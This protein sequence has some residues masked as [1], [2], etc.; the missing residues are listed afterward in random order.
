M[1]ILVHAT[2]VWACAAAPAAAQVAQQAAQVY[3]GV[4]LTPKLGSTVPL[5]LTFT[6]AEREAIELRELF[7]QKKPVV[8]TFVYHTCPMLCSAVLDGLT[9]S[10][11][12]IPWVPGR[13][14]TLVA[15]SIDAEDTAERSVSVR[16]RYLGRLPHQDAHWEFLTGDADAI[17]ALTEA[18]G[19]GFKWVES[20]QE[21][22]HPAA[23]IL[24][25]SEG[26]I[27]RYLPD[28]APRPRDLRASIVEASEGTVGGLLDRAFLY[29]F[30][31]D[32]T[33]NSYVLAARRAM[34]V[35]GGLTALAL[36][37]SLSLL[38]AREYRRAGW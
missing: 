24:L 6:N 36:L 27:A 2:L 4:G 13:D 8:L 31:F 1:R 33:A 30:Q 14:F 9:R 19:F 34:K 12:E 37:A 17:A 7:G 11:Q 25:T 28:M 20:Q 38:W 15:V 5:D 32:P 23:V 35:G 3:A 18:T 16:E 21:Y 26:V 22:A 10:L 29:C